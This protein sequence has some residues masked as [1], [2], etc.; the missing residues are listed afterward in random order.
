MGLLK[1]DLKWV[2]LNGDYLMGFLNWD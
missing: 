2:F 1:D